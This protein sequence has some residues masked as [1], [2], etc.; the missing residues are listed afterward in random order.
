M[1]IM[2]KAVLCTY[3]VF[4]INQVACSTVAPDD[5]NNDNEDN[6]GPSTRAIVGGVVGGLAGAVVLILPIIFLW[7]FHIRKK[8]EKSSI[9]SMECVCTV[10]CVC[11]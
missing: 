4:A 8:G 10:M 7:F 5:D 6:T 9:A 3:I 2:Q 11:I 1:Y